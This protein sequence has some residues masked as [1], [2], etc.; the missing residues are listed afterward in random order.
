MTEERK[1]R[2]RRPPQFVRGMVGTRLDDE[3]RQWARQQEGGVSKYLR[4][5]LQEDMKRQQNRQKRE[6]Q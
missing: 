6:G 1:P 2:K 3:E 4:R 5:L